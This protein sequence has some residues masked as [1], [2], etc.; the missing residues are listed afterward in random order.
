MSKLKYIISVL[1]AVTLLFPACTKNFDNINNNGTAFPEDLQDYD[2]QKQL[3]PFK[4]IQKAII[5]QTGIDGTNWQ[6]QIMQNLVA[7]MYSGYFHDRVAGFN[8]Q[9]SAY[10]LNT[11]WCAAQWKFTYSQGL[12]NIKTAEDICTE[13]D[14]PAFLAVAKIL[15]VAMMHRVTDYYGPIVY[16]TFAT[17]NVTAETQQSVY[18]AFFADL[19]LAV[20]LLDEYISLGG[21]E[22]FA[23]VDIMMP[24]GKRTYKYWIKFANS[25]RL[26]LAMRLSLVDDALA[27]EQTIKALNPANGGVLERA[28]D[29]IGQ[30]GV[31]N[32]LGGV[33]SWNEVFMNA[34]MESF[35]NGYQDPR[36]SK[37]YII[38]SG[39]GNIPYVYNIENKYK[40]I[41]QGH[42]VTSDDRYEYHSKTS[43]VQSTP[44]I[45]MTAAEI[46]F[47]RAEAA[48][49]G[50]ITEDVKTCYEKGVCISFEQWGVG[51]ASIYLSSD[52][53]PI[54]YIDAFDPNLNAS[55]STSITPKWQ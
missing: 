14:F 27:R 46:W 48:L 53:I 3:I 25:L 55:A 36:I 38:A 23:R 22:T 4:T 44:I 41:R 39:G 12:P 8:N 26:R 43:V 6:F 16:N 24:E 51:N 45:V 1:F 29:T 40:G 37:Y 19:D 21:A 13:Q 17:L 34:N 9:N 20:S 15:K 32:P 28:D 11:S 49:R 10:A 52:N 7:D 33:S 54:N 5:Y 50:Y 2:Y 35:L 18:N 47:L 42:A 31:S 30:S